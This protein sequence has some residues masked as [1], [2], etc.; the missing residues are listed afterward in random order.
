MAIGERSGLS[1]TAVMASD[2]SSIRDQ[3][4]PSADCLDPSEVEQYASGV[5]LS[6]DRIAHVEACRP[7]AQLL[8]AI[9]PRNLSYEKAWEEATSL[10]R[11]IHTNRD[12]ALIVVPA[13]REMRDA[14]QPTE[15]KPPR[16]AVA[17]HA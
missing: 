12:G 8:D 13:S 2:A 16:A 6:S 11:L 7:C 3:P 10:L 17:G 15:A 1:A 9:S 5:A 4:W 14:D